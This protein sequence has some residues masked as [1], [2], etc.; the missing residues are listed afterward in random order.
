MKI[1]SSCILLLILIPLSAFPQLFQKDYST[2][3]D[4]LISDKNLNLHLLASAFINNN[5]FFNPYQE[6][7][8]LIGGF[9]QPSLIYNISP[10]L[11]LSAGI[12]L[13]EYYGN[14]DFTDAEPVFSIKYRPNKE[15][16]FLAG[17]YEGGQNHNLPETLLAFE[18]HFSDLIRNGFL[19]NINKSFL[20]TEAWLDWQKYIKPGDPFREEF[21]IGINNRIIYDKNERFYLEIPFIILAHHAGGQINVTHLPVENFYNLSGGIE[22]TLPPQSFNHGISPYFEI[23]I[24]HSSGDYVSGKGLA[25]QF[26][27]GIE[28]KNFE[29]NAGYFR[30]HNF[31]SF[32][33]LPLYTSYGKNENN[34]Y[35]LGGI[36]NLLSFKTGYKVKIYDASFLFLR[37][38]SYYH[39][40]F[41]KIDYTF[42]IHM[43]VN[44]IISITNLK[45]NKSLPK[46]LAE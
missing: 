9:L 42:G 44:N 12:H 31:M 8:T 34:G 6:G 21:S 40:G 43:Q 10:K 33:G 5:E 27:A 38:E 30:G 11:I 17:S 36:S 22:V 4:S 28:M 26:T 25:Q 35:I 2:S 45:N 41:K 1:F 3:Y 23:L 15:I 37:F 24:H 13:R 46:S 7:Y 19:L 39:T 29:M 20:R 32:D 18:N 14:N 16:C